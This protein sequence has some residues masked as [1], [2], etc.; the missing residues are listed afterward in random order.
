MC[1][2]SLVDNTD[3]QCEGSRLVSFFLRSFDLKKKNARTPQ[4]AL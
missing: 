3:S 1:Q 2:D 4:S